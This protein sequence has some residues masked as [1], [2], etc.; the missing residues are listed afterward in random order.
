[1]LDNK[2]TAHPHRHPHHIAGEYISVMNLDMSPRDTPLLQ[3]YSAPRSSTNARSS[4]QSNCKE[5]ISTTTSSQSLNVMN[6]LSPFSGSID[7]LISYDFKDHHFYNGPRILLALAGIHSF[8]KFKPP[9][10]IMTLMWFFWLFQLVYA[11]E[12]I[13]A[14]TDFHF[15]YQ[16]IA[17]LIWCLHSTTIYTI[18]VKTILDYDRLHKTPKFHKYFSA[19]EYLLSAGVVK[20]E[21]CD[22]RS[23]TSRNNEVIKQ[24]DE[25]LTLVAGILSALSIGIAIGNTC[26]IGN[27][28]IGNKEWETY[29]PI[30]H[31]VGV[32]IP[33]T[34]DD[35]LSAA[36]AELTA[37]CM[38]H[39]HMIHD[40]HCTLYCMQL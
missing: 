29:F 32:A 22:S 24:E 39:A 2:I 6:T 35:A 34:C 4:Q 15:I 12:Q 38:Q 14:N 8:G 7:N 25:K 18:V 23:C 37:D 26:I 17:N 28:F 31:S 5:E 9:Y 27:Q 33:G 40:A 16:R 21:T 20:R 11:I 19:M 3:S 13:F 36:S 10:V 1:V 30:H